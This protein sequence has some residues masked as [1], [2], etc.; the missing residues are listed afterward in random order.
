MKIISWS[1]GNW[2]ST[3]PLLK[4]LELGA[5]TLQSKILYLGCICLSSESAIRHAVAIYYSEY[6]LFFIGSGDWGKYAM[7]WLRN[8]F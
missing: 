3:S 1:Y 4:A 6:N 8:V 5:N 2:I 7:S